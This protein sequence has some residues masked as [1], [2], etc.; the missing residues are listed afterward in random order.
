[1]KNRWGTSDGKK[2]KLREFDLIWDTER[3]VIFVVRQCCQCRR[4]LLLSW[5][6]PLAKEKKRELCCKTCSDEAHKK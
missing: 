1:M 5:D 2:P 4:G 3:K 6:R